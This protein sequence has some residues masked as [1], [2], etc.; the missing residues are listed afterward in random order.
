MKRDK[1][2]TGSLPA[3][4][5]VRWPCY[6]DEL[7]SIVRTYGEAD[8]VI[9]S[10]TLSPRPLTEAELRRRRKWLARDTARYGLV[11]R[12]LPR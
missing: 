7:T 11:N 8:V 4:I 9:R 3:Q 5:Q 2:A 1:A 12:E 10:R 6:R